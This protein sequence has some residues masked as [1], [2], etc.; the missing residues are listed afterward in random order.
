MERSDFRIIERLNS[1]GK[2]EF[3]IQHKKHK[4]VGGF[5]GLFGG[6]MQDVWE[7]F[8]LEVYECYVNDQH[9]FHKYLFIQ[10]WKERV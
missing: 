1:F 4:M 6:T 5:F 8:Y 7:D 3:I 2:S 9:R 10:N